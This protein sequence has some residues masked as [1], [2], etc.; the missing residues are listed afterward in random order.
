MSLPQPNLD[1]KTFEELVEESKKLIPTYAS[2]WTDFNAHDPGIT[3][4]E[5]FA[6][7]T[8]MQMYRMN[9]ITDKNKLKFLK[10]LGIKPNELASSK[11][12]VTFYLPENYDDGVTV[13]KGTQINAIDAET[14]ENIVFEIDDDV[15]VVPMELDKVISRDWQGFRDNTEANSRDGHYYYVFGEKAEEDSNLYLGFNKK[16]PSGTKI[17]LMVYLYEDDLIKRGEHGDELFDIDSPVDVEWAYYDKCPNDNSSK[18]WIE[19]NV[20]EKKDKT[21]NF[22]FS[23]NITFTIQEG[24]KYVPISPEE[25]ILNTTEFWIRCRLAKK[26]YDIPPRVKFIQLNTISATHGETIKDEPV[27]Y[28]NGL[29]NQK[30]VLK[31]KPIVPESEAVSVEQQVYQKVD[32]FDASCPEHLHYIIDNDN[33]EI[34]FGDGFN[35]FIPPKDAKIV[36]TYRTGGGEIGNV[37]KETIRQILDPEINGLT[38]TNLQ[39]ASGGAEKETID[40]AIFR[41]RKDLKEPYQAVTSHD[42][43]YIAKYTPGLR[44]R[45]AKAIEDKNKALVTVIVVPEVIKNS[46]Y[47]PELS[48]SSRIAVYNHLCKHRLITTQIKVESPQYIQISVTATVRIKPG[49]EMNTMAQ[50]IEELL[51]TFLNPLTGGLNGE[52]WPFGRPVFKSEVYECIY[53]MD[54]VDCIQQISMGN[55]EYDGNKI[56]IPANGL[57][58]SENHY[59]TILG[60]DEEC[61]G[62]KSLE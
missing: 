43:E 47:R 50:K 25:E 13:P 28:S 40:D 32:D 9:Q 21:K 31:K 18:C 26:G 8:E 6:W 61:K 48:E 17:D 59:I 16:P 19:L 46:T 49:Y 60:S 52:G 30:I 3:F 22:S 7:L 51:K 57:V 12:D 45:R 2:D 36:V 29:P 20:E 14:G 34:S 5:L 23:G 15:E 55:G 4:I 27:F 56:D 1:D 58:Y 24:M 53:N 33:G 62:G 11:V 10:L 39:A 54:G 38:V 42:Y 41:L 44:I 35:G 37:R